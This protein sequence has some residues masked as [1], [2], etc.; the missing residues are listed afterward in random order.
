MQ[1]PRGA[2]GDA[3]RNTQVA[4]KLP[5]APAVLVTAGDEGAAYCCRSTKGEHT[6][7]CAERAGLLGVGVG[8]GVA[9]GRWLCSLAAAHNAAGV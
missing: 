1:L 3:A 2:G 6:G 8:G 7:A 5:N 9:V 4:D